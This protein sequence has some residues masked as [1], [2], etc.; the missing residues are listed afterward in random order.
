MVIGFDE[1][2]FF[3]AKVAETLDALIETL[4]PETTPLSDAE[5]KLIC[6]VASEVPSYVLLFAVAPSI[7][8]TFGL[9]T[10]VRVLD[11]PAATVADCQLESPD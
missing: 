1:P 2:M 9:M 10:N 5:P 6:E 3:V 11:E 8:S 7:D 4:S